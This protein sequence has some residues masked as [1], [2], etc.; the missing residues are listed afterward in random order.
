M[1]SIL[2]PS[3]FASDL[4]AISK[5][6]PKSVNR[7]EDMIRDLVENPSQGNRY[8]G[9]GSNEVRKIRIGLPEYKIS[10]SNGLRLIFGVKPEKK[11]VALL[12]IYFKN[13]Y[14]S[15]NDIIRTAIERFGNIEA[16]LSSDL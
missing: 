16:N 14:K 13:R 12:T 15:E 1:Y 6:F 5:N 2:R 4:K 10:Q 11:I 8:P 9:F 7:I 3:A